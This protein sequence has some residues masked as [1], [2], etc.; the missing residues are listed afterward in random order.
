MPS[1]CATRR[2]SSTSAH[3][4]AA[5]VAVAAPQPHRHADD[6]VAL[7]EQQRAGDRRVDPA[8][9]RQQHLHQRRRQ[10]RRRRDTGRRS[11]STARSTSAIGG[12]AAE[13]H[14]QARRRRRHA[15]TPIA[16][17]TC[18]GSI[19]PLAHADA[20]LAHTSALVEQVQQRLA[21]DAV[22]A[23]RAPTRPP[24]DRAA[25]SR[26][27]P[28]TRPA[29]PSTRRSRST[30]SALVLGV[31]LGVGQRPAPPPARR[32]RRRCGCRCAARAPGRR[33]RSSGVDGRA[34]ADVSTPTP[35]GPPNLWALSDIMS[36]SGAIAPQVEPVRGL[37]GVGVQQGLRREPADE[38]RDRRQVGDRADL[39]VDR[40]HRHHADTS[41]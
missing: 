32:S 40:H 17:S 2:A 9:H 35:F 30:P 25:R 39:V 24:C 14:P 22:D 5:G 4:A 23:A 12:G 38:R 7:L 6:V 1:C 16:A 37:H 20:A 19:A 27:T 15:S 21:L 13:R 41:G 33:R 31:A 18:E 36:T 28:S 8:A 26:W 3:A 11:T 10:R 29:S 34:V